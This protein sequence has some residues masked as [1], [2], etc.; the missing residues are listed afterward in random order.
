MQSVGLAPEAWLQ[1]EVAERHAATENIA[2]FVLRDPAG[3]DLPAFSAGAHIEIELPNG[4]QRCY[5]LCNAP[6]QD[7]AYEI[8]ILRDPTGRGGSMSAHVDLVVGRRLRIR[9]RCSSAP[10]QAALGPECARRCVQ[11]P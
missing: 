10:T 1:V 4:M 6:G 5:S 3:R 2:H 11:A 8:A 7:A 9:S